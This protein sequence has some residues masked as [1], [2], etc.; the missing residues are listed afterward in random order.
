MRHRYLFIFPILLVAF[1]AGC[2]RGLGVTP[3]RPVV[4]LNAT[5]ASLSSGQNATL[6]WSA[7]N[8]TSV[9]IDNGIGSVAMSGSMTVSPKQTTTY[10]ITAT[11]SGETTSAQATVTVSAPL[12]P[13]VTI[14]SNVSTLV[15]G[16]PA[17]LTVTAANASQVVVS[18]NV[19]QTTATLSSTGGTVNV[20]PTH[21][22]TYTA[23]ATGNGQTAAATVTITVTP[24][25]DQHAINHV[26]FLMQEN[27][28]FDSYFGML[29]PYRKA[30]GLNVGDNGQEFDV[31]GLD[32]SMARI[33][34]PNDEGQ[35]FLPFKLA[36]SCTDDMSSAWLESYGDVNR[37]D[38]SPGRSIL[39]NG[40]VHTAEGEAKSSNFT[41]KLGKRAMGYYDQGFLN[42]Y[43]FMASQF[44]V[45]DRWFTPISSKTV[46]N[47]IAVLS[48]GTTQ[49]LVRDPG[50]DDKLGDL[51]FATIFRELDSNNVSWKIYYSSTTSSS[52]P[53]PAT[54]FGFFNDSLKYLNK[55]FPCSGN[56]VPS[57]AVG[58]SS[59]SFCIDPTHI[60]P[61]SQFF[62]DLQKGQLAQFVDIEPGY[63]NGT[64]E[65]PGADVTVGQRQ[66]STIINAFMQSSL[67]NDSV[68]FFAF[69]EGGGPFDH[70]PPVPGHTNDYTDASLHITTDIGSI[71]VNA[72]DFKPCPAQPGSFHCDLQ[73][74]GSY[75]DPGYNPG[76]APAQ[77]GFKAQLGFRVPNIVISPFTRKHYVSHIPMD[78]TA[79]IKFIENRF[80]GSGAHLTN[81]DAAQPDLLDF[82]D[83][84]AVPWKVPPSPPTPASGAC[85]IGNLGG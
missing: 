20:T 84:S 32:G 45:S 40:F 44:A 49:G 63:T 16:Q 42:Y 22:V 78:H 37:N 75:A 67:W 30:N 10:T 72:D 48:G 79:I 76:D 17:V 64:D 39:M 29:N 25:P 33:A 74:Y 24:P 58:D 70:V 15:G 54:T 27:R 85:N 62:T 18:N 35:N 66:I 21:T 13:T 41:D 1:A 5:P 38:F 50:V 52:N 9:Q 56:T 31:D 65:H 43:Y 14:T 47:R 12:G 36:T 60:A 59:N 68:F 80:I 57:S 55:S 82:F 73:S 23:T 19:D 2:G 4:T 7:T 81:R 53:Y 6:T 83:F 28:S 3:T 69:D 46:P 77:Q 11:G 34:N 51:G 61:L 71:A 8:A 26:I